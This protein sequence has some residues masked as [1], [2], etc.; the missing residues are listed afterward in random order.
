[1]EPIAGVTY[2]RQDGGIWVRTIEELFAAAPFADKEA[3]SSFWRRTGHGVTHIVYRHEI[4]GL[5][6]VTELYACRGWYG[7]GTVRW[8]VQDE[9]SVIW[10]EDQRKTG[11]AWL[12]N[13]AQMMGHVPWDP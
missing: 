9:G 8:L 7:N 3:L 1:M 4:P 13:K 12:K 11:K 10:T 2:D 6:S 5:G